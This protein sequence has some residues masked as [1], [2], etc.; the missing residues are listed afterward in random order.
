M[1]GDGA[2]RG[3]G[4]VPPGTGILHIGVGAFFK[5]FV[6]PQVGAA[7][8]ASTDPDAWGIL[9]LCP[10]RA[11]ARDA[12]RPGGWRYHAVELAPDGA[13]ARCID[14]LTG[15]I[16]LP[17]EPARAIAALADPAIRIV[18]LTV[19]EKGYAHEPATGRLAREHPD[20]AH[21]LAHDVTG[22]DVTGGD[23]AGGAAPRSIAGLLLAALAARRRAGHRPFTAISCDNLPENGALL[24]GLVLELAR[25]REA[26]REAGDGA[27]AGLA[28]WIAA[29]ARFP[30]S[31]VDRIVPAVTPEALDAMAEAIGARDPGA[32]AHEPFA[33]WVIEDDFVDGARPAFEAAGVTMVDDVAPHEAMK[34]RMLNGSHSALAYLGY[35][36]GHGTIAEAVADEALAGFVRALWRKEM[37]PALEA[38][39]GTDLSAYAGDLMARY[40][41]PAIRH[42][43]WQIAMDGSQKLPQRLLG[44]ARDNL[45]AGRPIPRVALAVAAWMRYVAGMDERGEAIDVR[46]PMAEELRSRGGAADPV[47]ALLALEPVFGDL[48]REPRFREAVAAAHAAL[49][50]RG[51]RAAAGALA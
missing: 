30:S 2:R 7:A 22:G 45:R 46:D 17:E 3:A 1:S 38:P 26:A 42:R 18:T 24:R 44:T 4:A 43:T 25:A 5:A 15:V 27:D 9:G 39:P 35:L 48:G 37:I 6:A 14:A 10:R 12:L 28:D 31:M 34:L 19:T 21:D 11:E 51:A 8:A 33:Q 16:V 50:E 20:V 41:N 47:D 23:T 32:V 36:A 29:E 49:T 40:R 13:R